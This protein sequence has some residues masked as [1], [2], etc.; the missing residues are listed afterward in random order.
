MS[1]TLYTLLNS[2]QSTA[3]LGQATPVSPAVIQTLSAQMTGKALSDHLGHFSLGYFYIDGELL[4]QHPTQRAVNSEYVDT[5]VE[6]FQ[7]GTIQRTEN[8][9]VVIGLGEGWNKLKNTGEVVYRISKDS[10]MLKDLS[11]GSGGAIGQVI[12]GGHRTEAVRRLSKM[13]DMGEEGYW[14]YQV[15]VPSKCSINISY[16][17]LNLF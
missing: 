6:L 14:Y 5:L 15:L 8:A 10:P 2:A 17:L 13:P 4:E 9:G 3:G 1:S 12:R 7:S 11:I 16:H